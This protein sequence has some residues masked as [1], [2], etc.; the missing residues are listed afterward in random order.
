MEASNIIRV[1]KNIPNKRGVYVYIP[2][3]QDDV[4]KVSGNLILGIKDVVI[5]M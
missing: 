4:L 2:I 3:K 1:L 5:F